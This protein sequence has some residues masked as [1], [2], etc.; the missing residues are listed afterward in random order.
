M[1]NLVKKSEDLKDSEDLKNSDF[2]DDELK[3]LK[4]FGLEPD[5]FKKNI[6]GHPKSATGL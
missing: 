3:L 4:E 6:Q 2:Q 1:E 5:V